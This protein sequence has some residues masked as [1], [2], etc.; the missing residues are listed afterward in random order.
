MNQRSTRSSSSRCAVDGDKA[1]L[2]EVIGLLQDPL[3]RPALRMVKRP[4]DAEDATQEVARQPGRRP[5]PMRWPTFAGKRGEAITTD[6]TGSR[7]P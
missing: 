2:E 1:A 6:A 5:D 7:R 4:S 3:Y